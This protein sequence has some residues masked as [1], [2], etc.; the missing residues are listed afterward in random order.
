LSVGQRYR[1]RL[2]MCLAGQPDLLM[3]DE[4]ANHLSASLVDELARAPTTTACAVV[5]ATHDR[6]MLTDPAGRA[7]GPGRPRLLG[8][9][10]SLV[11]TLTGTYQ[12]A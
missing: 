8:C 7:R 10:A 9:G 2:A 1:V 3:L 12:R 5:V 6:Q 11:Y 4:P